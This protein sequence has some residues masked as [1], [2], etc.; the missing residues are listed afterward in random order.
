MVAQERS[1]VVDFVTNGDIAGL[2]TLVF[3]ELGER[4]GGEA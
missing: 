1:D 3:L 2:A 4:D